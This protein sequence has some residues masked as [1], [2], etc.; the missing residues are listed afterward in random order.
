MEE[1][2]R[3]RALAEK[4]LSHAAFQ[5]F[6]E[7]LSRDPDLVASFSKV[8]STESMVQPQMPRST[9]TF[10][11]SQQQFPPPQ[12]NTHVGMTM[13]PEMPVDLSSLQIGSQTQWINMQEM[14]HHSMY[15]QPSVFTVELPAEPTVPIDFSV[16]SGKV[17]SVIPE[18]SF[19]SEKPEYVELPLM[20]VQ[21]IEESSAEVEVQEFDEDDPAFALYATSICTKS[22]APVESEL[23]FSASA[24]AKATAHIE[25]VPA[26]QDCSMSRQFQRMTSF[27]DISCRRLEAVMSSF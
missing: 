20:T 5:P 11:N 22:V 1:N 4:L 24:F 19:V 6:L 26:E 15:Q 9:D 14:P 8:T 23:I 18:L 3:Y 2:A 16:L 7:D 21:D 17:E 27:L 10:A 25:L 12:T 13:I